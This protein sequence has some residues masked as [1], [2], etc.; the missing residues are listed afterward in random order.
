MKEDQKLSAREIA[1]LERVKKNGPLCLQADATEAGVDG[2]GVYLLDGARWSQDASEDDRAHIGAWPF[3]APT[4]RLV[5]GCAG[6]NMGGA[7]A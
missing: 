5:S 3:A 7:I 2:G 1:A 4:G 6:P